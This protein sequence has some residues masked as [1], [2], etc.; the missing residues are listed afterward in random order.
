M[1]SF[2]SVSSKKLLPPILPLITF[3]VLITCFLGDSRAVPAGRITVM[4]RNLYVGA[5]FSPLTRVSAPG[6]FADRVA[7]VYGRILSSRF[8]CRAEAIADE[9]VRT[10]PDVVALQEAPLMLVQ[11]GLEPSGMR[12]QPTEVAMDYLQI[13]LDALQRRHVHY[14]VAAIVSNTDLSAP[15]RNRGTI[16]FIDRDAILVR[17][18]L[19]P[20][21]LSV[22]NTHAKNFEMQSKLEIAGTE[23]TLLRGWCSVDVA[24]RGRVVRIVNT[25]LEEDFFDLSQFFQAQELLDGPFRT[26]LPVI[27]LGDFNTR[28]GSDVYRYFRKN[29][30]K[31]SWVLTHPG[32][33]GFSCCQDE[34]LL[35]SKSQLNERIDLILYYGSQVNAEVVSLVGTNPSDRIFSGQWPSD[36]AGVVAELSIRKERGLSRSDEGAFVRNLSKNPIEGSPRGKENYEH[37]TE[38]D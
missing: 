27:A 10:R 30:F 31:D 15:S 8:P 37:K 26:T 21:E 11:V 34:D 28:K 6:E 29:G 20:G 12:A 1:K 24:V 23:V 16:R 2:R 18:D 19:P 9:I 13:L 32:D 7:Q 33:P 36:H 14:A 5:S 4:T 3:T 22:L 25:H 38:T 35:N 17:T